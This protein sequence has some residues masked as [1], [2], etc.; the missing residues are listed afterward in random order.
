MPSV[1]RNKFTNHKNFA[2][3]KIF[4]ENDFQEEVFEQIKDYVSSIFIGQKICIFA[5]GQTGAG[6][7]YTMEGKMD[8]HNMPGQ[9]KAGSNLS[10]EA[11]IIPRA[12]DHIF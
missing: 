8:Y 11:G 3:D 2:F 10:E 9:T 5:Y 12:V 6:K 7:T 4:S 1:G